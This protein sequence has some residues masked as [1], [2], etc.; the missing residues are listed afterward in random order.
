MGVC[1][2][3]TAVLCRGWAALGLPYSGPLHTAYYLPG[4]AGC[5]ARLPSLCQPEP[6]AQALLEPPGTPLNPTGRTRS[7]PPA[8]FVPRHS[9]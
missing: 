9:V 4:P 8:R 2:T 3:A 6:L 7:S 5:V 1:H